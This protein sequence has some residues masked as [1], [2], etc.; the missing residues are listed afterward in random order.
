MDMHEM[1]KREQPNATCYIHNL[2]TLI[3]P[4]YDFSMHASLLRGK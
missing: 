4:T 2:Q 3:V 1:K